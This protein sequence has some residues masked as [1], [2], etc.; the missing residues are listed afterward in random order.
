MG[1]TPELS[2]ERIVDSAMRLLDEEGAAGLTMR[3]LARRLGVKAASLYYHVQSQ[4]DLVDALQGRINDE[5]DLAPLADLTAAGFAAFVRSYRDAY[6]R[7]PHAIPLVNRRVV[8]VPSALRLYDALA[9][10]LIGRG[11]PKEQVM[12]VLAVI[13]FVV[14]GSAGETLAE[15]FDPDPGIYEPELPSLAAALRAADPET[16]DALSFELALG[17]AS[18]AISTRLPAGRL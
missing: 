10:H 9:E 7:H 2:R 16:V 1:R 4:D 17:L 8:R 6:R 12:V 18:A 5:V 13:D 3:G 15:D 11:V 14:L